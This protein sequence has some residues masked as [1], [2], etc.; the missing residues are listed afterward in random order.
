MTAEERV[1]A[2]EQVTQGRHHRS[3]YI[4]AAVVVVGAAAMGTAAIVDG[5]TGTS[6]LLVAFAL[7][8]FP[9]LVGAVVAL[10]LGR[11]L[12][13]RTPPTAGADP[14]TRRRIGR[15]LR[16]GSTDDPRLDALARRE[17]RLRVG[18]R[19]LLWVFAA[20][21]LT[22]LPALVSGAHPFTRVLA[23]LLILLL[24]AAAWYRWRGL[25][26]ARRYLTGPPSQ[27]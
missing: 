24:V 15:A 18:Q 9:P 27:P 21:V 25:R 20:G 22:Q 5:E 16:D 8:L 13:R 14:A 1:V 6:D 19:W 11:R 7:M 3:T 10:I 12:I 17:A 2:D 26:E 4:V 23:M